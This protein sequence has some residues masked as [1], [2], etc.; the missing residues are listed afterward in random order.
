M[1]N[2]WLDSSF[3]Q[4]KK[5][6]IINHGVPSQMNNGTALVLLYYR[7]DLEEYKVYLNFPNQKQSPAHEI[8]VEQIKLYINLTTSSILINSLEEMIDFIT[9]GH[10]KKLFDKNLNDNT[11]K[12]VNKL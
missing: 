7:D 1:E 5:S 10:E 3:V 4:L 9:V 2:S 8:S 6:A 11:Q 12:K